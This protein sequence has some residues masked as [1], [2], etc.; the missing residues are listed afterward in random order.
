MMHRCHN[1]HLCVGNIDRYRLLFNVKMCIQICIL[2][3]I[4]LVFYCLYHQL[5]VKE[6]FLPCA[7][8]KLEQKLQWNTL[9]L[10]IY[11]YCI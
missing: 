4:Y 3:T 8:L 2:F 7:E 5:I 6:V 9:V 11:L 1:S 10:L